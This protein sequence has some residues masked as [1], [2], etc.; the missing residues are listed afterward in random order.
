MPAVRAC[1]SSDRSVCGQLLH[2]HFALLGR[3]LVGSGLFFG[4]GFEGGE[5]A[6]AHLLK[7]G[8]TGSSGGRGLDRSLEPLMAQFIFTTFFELFS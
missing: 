3:Q 8:R 5:E 7:L 6:F 2:V 1:D 4:E